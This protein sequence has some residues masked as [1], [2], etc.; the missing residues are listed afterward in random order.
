MLASVLCLDEA[1]CVLDRESFYSDSSG[2]WE[3]TMREEQDRQ[4]RGGRVFKDPLV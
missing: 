1:T 4:K 2:W 3:Q